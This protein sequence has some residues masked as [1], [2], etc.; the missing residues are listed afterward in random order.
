MSSA[1]TLCPDIVAPRGVVWLQPLAVQAVIDLRKKISSVT[2][3]VLSLAPF[4]REGPAYVSGA[5]VGANDNF[6]SRSARVLR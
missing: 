5:G 6:S 3:M 2:I 1:A 4:F